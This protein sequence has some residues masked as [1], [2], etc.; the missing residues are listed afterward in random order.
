MV[1][2]GANP[3]LIHDT[4]KVFLDAFEKLVRN[5]LPDGLGNQTVTPADLGSLPGVGLVEYEEAALVKGHSTS[6]QALRKSR[7]V[8]IFYLFDTWSFFTAF[9]EF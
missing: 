4:L 7:L 2:T 9:G 6:F 5:T 8:T 3:E 1:A